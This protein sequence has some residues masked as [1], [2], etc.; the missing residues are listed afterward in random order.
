M[1]ARSPQHKAPAAVLALLLV[2]AA[3][4]PVGRAEAGPASH[5]WIYWQANDPS[6]TAVIDHAVWS[7]LLARYRVIGDDG[8]VRFAYGRVSAADRERL[9]AYVD[10]LAA[11]PITRYPRAEQ[12]AYWVNLYNALTIRVVLEHYPVDSIRDISLS[13]GMFSRGP[14]QAKLLQIEGQ[15]VSLDDIEHR[16][17]RPLWRDPRIH[18]VVNCASLGCPNLPAEALTPASSERLLES[19]AETFINHPRGA[20][21]DDWGLIVS[22]IYVWFIADF[23]GTDAGVIEHLRRYARPSLAAALEGVD[24]IAADAYDW[25]L[26]AAP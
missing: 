4:V 2:L 13:P 17:L 16:I 23:G 15:W 21:V 6:A 11:L 10:R 12:F 14:W 3:A 8:I 18:Y 22:S 19:G 5:P 1:S 24:R 9:A 7:E 26:N 25:T 20:H